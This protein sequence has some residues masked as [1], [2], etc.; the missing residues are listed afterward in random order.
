MNRKSMTYSLVMA[1]LLSASLP[2]AAQETVRVA[3][4]NF[5][6][7]YISM[8]I[9]NKRGYYAEESV[10]VEIILMA[11]L[12]STRALIGNSVEFGSASNPTA[13]V[14]GAKL[15]ILMVF[16]DKPPGILAAQPGI[17]SV[18][19][20]RGKRVGGSTVGSL[21]YG[22][23][24][25]LLPKF[26][27]QLEKDVTFVPVGSTSTRFTALR[28]GTIDASPLSPPSSF[29]AQDAGFPVLLRTAD[30]LEDIQAS[31]VATDERLARQGDLVRRFMRATVKGQRVYLANRQEG[32]TA[33]MEFTRNKDRELMARVYDDHMKTIA[34]DG[35]ISDRLQRIVIERS[36][37]LVN[38]TR[39]VRPEEIFD[40][41]YIRKAQAEVTQSG[42][43]P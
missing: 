6:A 23:M 11:G 18:A 8:F 29:L 17:K 3:V 36:K 1:I 7:S 4:S 38:V 20:L 32:I 24:K 5:S 9:A 22:W 21:E 34:R 2:A 31:I 19:E 37:R 27:L 39:E 35:T 41:S 33:I 10:A 16:N 12:T 42:W 14:Q 28:A 15:K 26:G 13:A 25:E 30:H 40:F 43:T